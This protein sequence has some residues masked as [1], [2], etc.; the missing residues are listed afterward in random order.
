MMKKMLSKKELK[1][2]IEQFDELIHLFSLF[3]SNFSIEEYAKKAQKLLNL[4]LFF[5][6]KYKELEL[7]EKEKSGNV[8][9]DYP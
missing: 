2:M 9:Q 1:R 4:K 3:Q 6:K 7:E 8:G 5:E